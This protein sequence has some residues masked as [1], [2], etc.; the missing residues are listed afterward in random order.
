MAILCDPVLSYTYESSI[1]R[2]TYEDL[3]D[4]IGLC[5]RHAQSSGPY[6]IWKRF[7]NSGTRLGRLWFPEMEGARCKIPSLRASSSKTRDFSQCG[8]T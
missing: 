5:A 4:W 7:S 2:Y 3:P 6:S 8:G 1:S